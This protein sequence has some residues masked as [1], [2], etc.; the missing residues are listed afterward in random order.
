MNDDRSGVEVLRRSIDEVAASL[1]PGARRRRRVAGAAAL[2]VFVAAVSA[3]IGGRVAR[4]VPGTP[5]Q[6]IEV[7]VL[8]VAGQDVDAHV[9]DVARAGTIVVSPRGDLR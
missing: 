6:R 4:T 2:V 1:P 9:V 5:H 3:W 8:R 7:K